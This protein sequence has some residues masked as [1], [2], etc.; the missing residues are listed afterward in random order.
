MSEPSANQKSTHVRIEQSSDEKVDFTLINKLTVSIASY[1]VQLSKCE[2]MDDIERIY[3]SIFEMENEI[4]QERK[5]DLKSFY[6]KKE[7]ILQKMAA[8]ELS[9]DEVNREINARVSRYKDSVVNRISQLE[10]EVNR[11]KSEMDLPTIDP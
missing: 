2:N 10:S 3:R 7:D 1:R 6:T 8:L 9:L 4:I 5:K 11:K